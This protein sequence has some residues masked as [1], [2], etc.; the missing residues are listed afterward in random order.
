MV[1][2]TMMMMMVTCVWRSLAGET[3]D[4]AGIADRTLILVR[5]GQYDLSNGQL[6]PLGEYSPHYYTTL[7]VLLKSFNVSK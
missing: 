1:M 7:R 2:M 4:T 5:H 6:T 3:R